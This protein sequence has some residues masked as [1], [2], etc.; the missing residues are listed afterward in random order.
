VAAGRRNPAG[1]LFNRKGL[2]TMASAT[3]TRALLA[4]ATL[5]GATQAMAAEPFNGPYPGLF[6]GRAISGWRT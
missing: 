4:S 3:F 2:H 5:L 1:G 6:T